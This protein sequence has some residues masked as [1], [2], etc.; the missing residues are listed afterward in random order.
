MPG[1]YLIQRPNL[2][3]IDYSIWR[4]QITGNLYAELCPSIV[5]LEIYVNLSKQYSSMQSSNSNSLCINNH[6]PDRSGHFDKVCIPNA[7]A[8]AWRHSHRALHFTTL[9]KLYQNEYLINKD[10]LNHFANNFMGKAYL[11]SHL[12]IAIQTS[13][14]DLYSTIMILM[15]CSM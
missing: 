9:D 10:E 14:Q 3:S 12:F 15:Q 7:K 5:W 1:P 8:N 6:L 4:M 11:H 2:I 13:N